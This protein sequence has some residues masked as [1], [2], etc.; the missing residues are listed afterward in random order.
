MP[1][2]VPAW[3]YPLF[4]TCDAN[5]ALVDTPVPPAESARAFNLMLETLSQETNANKRNEMM[6][7][8]CNGGAACM[9]DFEQLLS[10]AQVAGSATATVIR[11][12]LVAKAREDA[13]TNANIYK[14]IIKVPES[15]VDACR[16]QAAL[17][18]QVSLAHECNMQMKRANRLGVTGKNGSCVMSNSR[19]SPYMYPS[20]IR[21]NNS[22]KPGD[23]NHGPV[24]CQELD[25]MIDA[26]MAA[27]QDPFTAIAVSLM[28]NGTR[29]ASLYLD[30]IGV[31]EEIGCPVT[32]GSLANHNLNSYNTYYNVTYGV[33]ET[34]RAIS[35]VTNYVA[36]HGIKTKPGVSYYCTGPGMSATPVANQC[37]LKLPY[38]ADSI[39]NDDLM[40]SL[41]IRSFSRYF[42]TPLADQHRNGASG[43]ELPARRLQRYNGWSKAM[44]GAE[45]VTAWRSGVNYYETPTYGYQAMDFLLNTV[46]NNPYVVN[47]VRETAARL[48][49]RPRSILC[50]DVPAGSYGIDTEVYFQLHRDSPRMTA[51]KSSF[52]SVG[53]FN[54]MPRGF[55]NV[56]RG[57]FNAILSGA[58]GSYSAFRTA[59]NS[60]DMTKATREYFKSVWP[61]RSTIGKA[62]QQ[63]QGYTWNR[64]IS[65][66]PEWN[67]FI[68][69]FREQF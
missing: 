4:F 52:D 21:D 57:E 12:E 20:G 14:N 19:H 31:V 10:M 46:M 64:D 37:C 11:N 24:Q 13:R 29:V 54:G 3:S 7:N 58:A 56:L 69:A 39:T 59:Y 23:L 15:L 9:R 35:A 22:N 45:A 8:L 36:A 6:R 33:E 5:K 40:K 66:G 48:G 30:P 16:D 1:L 27:G 61:D 38:K 41:T 47:K 65:S 17:A 60:G 53:S 43:I 25:I 42:R 44:G 67:S 51:V 32:A 49:R 28:E 34:P 2:C 18:E 68:S 63:D 55:R 50:E 62:S 26:A